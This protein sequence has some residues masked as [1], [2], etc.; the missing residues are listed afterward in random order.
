MTA[1]NPHDPGTCRIVLLGATKVR[2][3]KVISMLNELDEGG[4]PFC[5]KR[6]IPIEYLPCIPTFDCYQDGQNCTI[7]Y[8]VKVDF[9]CA[10]TKAPDGLLQFFDDHHDGTTIN[11]QQFVFCGISGVAIGAG[12][13]DEQDIEK[14]GT[15]LERMSKRKLPIQVIQCNSEYESMQDETAAYKALCN[16]EKEHATKQFR[17]GP[18]KM[19]KFVRDVAYQIVRDSL[20]Q[21]AALA[22]AATMS[23]LDESTNEKATT[24]QQQP[25]EH[26][27]IDPDKN[28]YSCRKCRLVLFGQNDL[29]YPP[30][31]SSKHCFSH[32]KHD[33]AGQAGQ[34]CQSLFLKDKLPW[35]G[36]M[37]GPEGR[38]VC[39]KCATKMGNWSWSG[40]QCSCGTWV[41]P[42]LQIPRSKVDL[43]TPHP[44]AHALPLLDANDGPSTVATALSS[45]TTTNE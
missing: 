17:L 1:S 2:L 7:R 14:I 45:L 31:A 6:K 15:F 8:L 29:E 40:A 10:T 41:V 33:R 19:A 5:Y 24:K 25:M 12:I 43:V 38:I 11:P 42:A 3:F 26:H 18:G 23:A 20:E 37:N 22:V 13:E 4:D 28:R 30:H 32:R 34:A 9:Y 27:F 21:H 35:M 36:A 44:P 39:S 16:T